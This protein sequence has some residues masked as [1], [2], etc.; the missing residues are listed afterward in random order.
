[1]DWKRIDL[2]ATLIACPLFALLA[3]GCAVWSIKTGKIDFNGQESE[4]STSP[5]GFWFKFLLYWFYA[6]MLVALGIV[7]ASRLLK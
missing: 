7:A 2:W 3:V 1:M 4:R 6:A 5:I